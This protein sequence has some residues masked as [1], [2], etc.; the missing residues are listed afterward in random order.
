ME[1]HPVKKEPV[2]KKSLHYPVLKSTT[3]THRI[4]AGTVKVIRDQK[5]FT[6][7]AHGDI[8]V[9]KK[10]THTQKTFLKK[11]S[12]VISETHEKHIHIETLA[13]ELGI[14]IITNADSATKKLRTGHTVTVD[15][16]K[17]EVHRGGFH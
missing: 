4:A 2:E 17:G 9:L 8:L 7:I 6:H 14:P 16:R 5:D 11:A 13:K 15:G 10:L 3:T 12:A 1:P